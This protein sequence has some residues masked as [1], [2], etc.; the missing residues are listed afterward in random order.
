M[1]TSTK[2]GVAL[3]ITKTTV[4]RLAQRGQIPFVLLPSGHR[5]YDVEAVKAALDGS[6]ASSRGA[7]D[8]Q[9]AIEKSAEGGAQ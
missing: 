5:R 3:G 4:N 7:S 6:R 8:D 1:L 2:L 9:A